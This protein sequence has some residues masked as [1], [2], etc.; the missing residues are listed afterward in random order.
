MERLRRPL[1]HLQAL[2]VVAVLAASCATT[3]SNTQP[4]SERLEA[5][6][7]GLL[8]TD[9]AA[10]IPRLSRLSLENGYPAGMRPV[11]DWYQQAA[12][13]MSERVIESVEHGTPAAL[14]TALS[15]EYSLMQ[16]ADIGLVSE[17][18]GLPARDDIAVSLAE[19]LLDA[20]QELAGLSIY[21]SLVELSARPVAERE[22]WLAVAGALGDSFAAAAIARTLDREEPGVALSVDRLSEATVT[23]WVDRGIRIQDGRGVPD[24]VLGS[25]FYIDPDGYI[26]TNYHVVESEVDP[27][28]EGFSRAY[29][30]PPDDPQSRIPARVIGYDRFLDLALLKVERPSDVVVPITAVPGLPSG[31]PV[32]AI[33]SPGGLERTVTSGIV[34]AAGRRFLPVGNSIQVDVPINP[35]NSGGPLL[36][37][38]GRL[39]GIIFAGIEQFEGINFAIPSYWIRRMLPGLYAGGQAPSAWLGASVQETPR[40]LEVIYVM[41]GGPASSA[42][43][44]EGDIIVDIGDREVPEIV[45]A[46]DAL[47]RHGPGT[48]HPVSFLRDNRRL[49]TV[50]RA[51]Q[52]PRLPIAEALPAAE[53]IDLLPPLFGIESERTSS[54][55]GQR[56]VVTRVIPGSIGDEVGISERD[57]F[58]LRDWFVDV[59]EGY[60]LVEILVR[61]RT[62]GFLEAA[63]QL[64]SFLDINSFI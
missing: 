14:G 35:G 45:G 12:D 13:A 55:L 9:P 11:T 8:E 31:E 43:I 24:R 52:R 30:R 2:L 28:Y 4:R 5:E 56:Y 42:G 40:G 29:I 36:D 20:N 49:R 54:G 62:G 22:E 37:A 23:V 60:A 1:R 33:G 17:P 51:E 64:V 18:G 44:R 19:S 6:L 61:R 47:L 63:I 25:G 7:I 34:S 3:E 21:L 38:N 39:V 57:P 59:D 15:L 27:T 41:P 53:A 46:Q 32:V 48:L 10:I 16:L 26:L 50:I 58:Q